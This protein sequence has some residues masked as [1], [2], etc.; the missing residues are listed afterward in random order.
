MKEKKLKIDAKKLKLA[1]Y[2]N[3]QIILK[4]SLK[5]LSFD[6]KLFFK[7]AE[8]KKIK[9][10]ISDI[11]HLQEFLSGIIKNIDN[12]YYEKNV[13]CYPTGE[14]FFKISLSPN[15]TKK[16]KCIILQ[17]ILEMLK[18]LDI[19]IYKLRILKLYQE[20]DKNKS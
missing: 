14:L 4:K 9:N 18:N 17:D 2:E 20:K 7:R 1:T 16:E 5:K 11:K 6:K 19:I 10:T 13:N 3:S 8:K 12:E 15:V